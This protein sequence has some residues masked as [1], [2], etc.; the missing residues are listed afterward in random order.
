M[1]GERRRGWNGERVGSE[2]KGWGFDDPPVVSLLAAAC[3]KDA[4]KTVRIASGKLCRI[5]DFG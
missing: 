3:Q 4:M 2:K 5:E 1:D